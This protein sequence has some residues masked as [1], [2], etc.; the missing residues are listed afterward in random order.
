MKDESNG[1]GDPLVSI[2][3]FEWQDEPLI[4]RYKDPNDPV[5]WQ[6]AHEGNTAKN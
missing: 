3:I 5:R 6:Q 1:D 2:V 4:G